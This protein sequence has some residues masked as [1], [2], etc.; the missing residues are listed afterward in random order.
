VDIDATVELVGDA[1][2]LVG[3]AGR[4]GI[5]EGD[6]R[7]LAAHLGSRPGSTRSTG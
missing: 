3:M 6:V 1:N 7:Q 5:H 4:P 2:L